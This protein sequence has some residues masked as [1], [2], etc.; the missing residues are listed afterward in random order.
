[1]LLKKALFIIVFTSFILCGFAQ[2]PITNGL[3]QQN[4]DYQTHLSNTE[5]AILNGDYEAYRDYS[6]CYFHSDEHDSVSRNIILYSYVMAT[7]Y[8]NTMAAYNCFY[9]LGGPDGIPRDSALTMLLLRLLEIG[10]S[11]DTSCADLSEIGCA[12]YLAKWYGGVKYI[13]RDPIKQNYYEEL[14]NAMVRSRKRR[15][16]Q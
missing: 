14:V 11:G 10:A 13:S 2:E 16:S 3:T 8:R 7:V 4:F 1:M 15:L 12:T 6:I 5:I 9:F